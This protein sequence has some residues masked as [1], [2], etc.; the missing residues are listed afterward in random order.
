MVISYHGSRTGPSATGRRATPTAGGRRSSSSTSRRWPL[1][2]AC[3]WF[4][5]GVLGLDDPVADN[6]SAN[7]IGLALGLGARFYLF[8]IFVFKRPIQLA[9]H[10]RLAEDRTG[11]GPV[12]DEPRSGP[13]LGPR[14]TELGHQPPEQRQADADHV[15]VVALDAGD[16]RAAEPVDRER[17]GHVQRLAGRD[18]GRRSRRRT[19]RRSG[20]WS[21]RSRP[22]TLAG[23]RVAQ[24]VT[25]VQHAGAAAHRLPAPAASAASCGLPRAS[26]SSSSTE[27]QPSTSAP[28]GRSSRSA[29]AAHFSSASCSASSAGG[30]SSTCDSSTPDTITTGSMPALRRVASRA[31]EAEARTSVVTV[32]TLVR[33]RR[34]RSASSR[35]AGR[36]P[37]PTGCSPW[38]A[39]VR[40][41]TVMTQRQPASAR[42]PS[43]PHVSA[44]A[45]LLH[46][47]VPCG[48]YDRGRTDAH[49]HGS[50]QIPGRDAR[51]LHARRR[52]RLRLRR[53]GDGAGGQVRIWFRIRRARTRSPTSGAARR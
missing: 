42:S 46:S 19:R 25:G 15:V 35:Y 4:S 14:V 11:R 21:R 7:L 8:R 49:A 2:V 6:V 33:G 18:V 53:Q 28:A 29:T 1:P 50:A 47:G 40:L 26:P 43:R 51:L 52:P 36:S 22:P 44:E 32:V 5:R 37:L 34:G 38:E 10:L 45:A 30:R 17:A 13:Q 41:H 48:W 27:S 31:G 16:E 20:P 9:R 23:G 24:A 3:L 12:E 39:E